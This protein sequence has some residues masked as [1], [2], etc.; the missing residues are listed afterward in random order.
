MLYYHASRAIY[1]VED[2]IHVPE[3]EAALAYQLSLE[4]SH[5]WR[6]KAL[7]IAR[8]AR[9]CPRQ[10]AV[11]AATSLANAAR[12]LVSQP[13]PE[14]RP[15]RVYEVSI[16]Q[17]EPSPTVLIA[18]I[19][20]HGATFSSLAACM[21]EYWL[22]KQDWKFLEFVC[23]R[24]VVIAMLDVIEDME[25]LVSG[26]QYAEDRKLAE[27]I[28]GKP[29]SRPKPRKPAEPEMKADDENEVPE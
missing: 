10:T 3:G 1:K 20:A 7:E 12:F 8:K 15:V 5:A 17:P 25:L 28:W 18:Y 4:N 29:P 2:V 21:E 24:L 11:Y 27:K 16:T 26:E 19:D 13:D 9:S 14:R 23:Q 22:R 6:E